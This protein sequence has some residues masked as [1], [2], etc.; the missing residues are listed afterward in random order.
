MQP[1]RGEKGWRKEE[2]ID[3]TEGDRE[4]DLGP[5]WAKNQ[6]CKTTEEFCSTS[7]IR[8]QCLRVKSKGW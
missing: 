3:E 5:D 1:L 4:T 6:S 7:H 8:L 2:V